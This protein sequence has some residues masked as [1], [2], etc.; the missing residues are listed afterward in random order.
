MYEKEK[1]YEQQKQKVFKN[2]EKVLEVVKKHENKTEKENK[3][4]R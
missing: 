3:E 2:A 4:E 1:E